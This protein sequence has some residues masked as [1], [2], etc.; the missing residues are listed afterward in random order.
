M[1]A[2]VFA[3][4]KEYPGNTGSFVACPTVTVPQ[5]LCRGYATVTIKH[6]Q[7]IVY[8]ITILSLVFDKCSH[9]VGRKHSS[10]VL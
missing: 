1:S 3:R 8:E 2:V 6:F 10:N 9:N 5:L 7:N 4:L